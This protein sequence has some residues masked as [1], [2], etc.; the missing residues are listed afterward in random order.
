M[1]N[2]YGWKEP[3]IM[4]RVVRSL[5]S[6]F[7]GL[8]P[9]YLYL[10]EKEFIQLIEEARASGYKMTSKPNNLHF[11]GL[12]VIKVKCQSHFGIGL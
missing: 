10:G 11:H 6:N 12:S 4:T 3:T 2:D 8:A 1:F 7:L 5:E 9:K